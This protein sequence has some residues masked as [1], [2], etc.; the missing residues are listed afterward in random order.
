LDV[1]PESDQKIKLNFTDDINDAYYFDDEQI[2]YHREYY[3]GNTDYK[4]YNLE[5]VYIMGDK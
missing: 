5:I 3:F 1:D 2:S 4:K